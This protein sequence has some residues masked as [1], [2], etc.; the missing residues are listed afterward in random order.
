[1]YYLLNVWG[2]IT[3]IYLYLLISHLTIYVQCEHSVV[4]NDT[5]L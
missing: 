5:V 4:K 3:Y 1:M 2:G